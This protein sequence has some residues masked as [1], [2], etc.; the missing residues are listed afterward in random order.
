MTM[1]HRPKTTRSR[2]VYRA[3]REPEFMRIPQSA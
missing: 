2:M 1:L 3:G